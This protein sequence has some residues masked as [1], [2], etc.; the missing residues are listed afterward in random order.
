ME[1]CEVGRTYPSLQETHR[2]KAVQV[3]SLRPVLL[4][5]RSSGAA[6]EETQLTASP[7]GNAKKKT[8]L[9][10]ARKYI[11]DIRN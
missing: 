8:L 4:P 7:T 3:P 1:V 11:C 10:T 6:Y 2:R 5:L 9:I